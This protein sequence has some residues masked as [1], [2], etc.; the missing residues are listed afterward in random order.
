MSNK[1]QENLRILQL[2]LQGRLNAEDLVCEDRPYKV[3]MNL[4][5]TEWRSGSETMGLEEMDLRQRRGNCR[6]V[7][8]DLNKK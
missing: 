7:T 2:A 8:L 1:R 4:N 5:G 6:S 3:W